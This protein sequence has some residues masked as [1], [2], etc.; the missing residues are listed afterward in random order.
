MAT[1]RCSEQT[2]L[3]VV[4]GE[5]RQFKHPASL[6]RPD[7]L[8]AIPQFRRPASLILETNWS[9]KAEMIQ[10]PYFRTSLVRDFTVC[11]GWQLPPSRARMNKT[12]YNVYFCSLI[13]SLIANGQC[14]YGSLFRVSRGCGMYSLCERI[15]PFCRLRR[16]HQPLGLTRRQQVILLTRPPAHL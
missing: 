11:N 16:H 8:L 14:L 5:N 12:L 4:G 3:L 1:A 7:E 6:H 15:I 13:R 9:F 2:C 10:T